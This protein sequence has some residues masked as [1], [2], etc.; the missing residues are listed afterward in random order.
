M[1]ASLCSTFFLTPHAKYFSSHT[2]ET[3]T[4][5]FHMLAPKNGSDPSIWL[6]QMI[7]SHGL[8]RAKLPG[9]YLKFG[10]N[11]S[12]ALLSNFIFLP[13]WNKTTFIIMSLWHRYTRLF[14]KNLYHMT[15]ATVKAWKARPDYF[16]SPL[17]L[18][19]ARII[20]VDLL[21]SYSNCTCREGVTQLQST[22]L[23]S[24]LP[25]WIGGFP[26]ILSDLKKL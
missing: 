26:T 18:C 14:T 12:L 6:S 21:F 17:M 3:K 2:V 16:S 22:S 25:W 20:K 24:V 15:F 13:V 4:W 9:W 7:G 1:W 23:E 10:I 19:Y 11:I 8:L 5:L